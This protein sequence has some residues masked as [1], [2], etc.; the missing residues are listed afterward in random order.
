MLTVLES[1]LA[2]EDITAFIEQ[3]TVT[4]RELTVLEYRYIKDNKYYRAFSYITS[5][6]VSSS[7]FGPKI[8]LST[9]YIKCNI[10]DDVANVFCY[11]TAK[12][13]DLV[14]WYRLS[15]LTE[16][17]EMLEVQA[18]T[19]VAYLLLDNFELYGGCTFSFLPVPTIVVSLV[20]NNIFLG[21]IGIDC[22]TCEM[23]VIT[24]TSSEIECYLNQ[25]KSGINY[26]KYLQ[27]VC[28]IE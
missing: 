13:L 14:P 19:Y 9:G 28:H 5:A 11:D 20:K 16:L 7:P 27:E 10:L 6:W 8:D 2:K 26:M 18:E 23:N 15:I 1:L 25:I 21:S 4:Y 22:R 24:Q 17:Y 3:R 12:E